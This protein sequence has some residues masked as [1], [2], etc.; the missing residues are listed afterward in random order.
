MLSGGVLA[1]L[2]KLAWFE[3]DESES[4]NAE[5]A[6]SSDI[7]ADWLRAP[8]APDGPLDDA[9]PPFSLRAATLPS[10]APSCAARGRRCR[11]REASGER[12]VATRSKGPRWRTRSEISCTP[13]RGQR[14]VRVGQTNEVARGVHV[15]CSA[16]GGF[17]FRPK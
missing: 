13:P 10:G 1:L 9:K 2:S 11:R 14:D 8:N 12:V 4:S 17:G 7:G 5:M 3:L 6:A 15:V 16:A